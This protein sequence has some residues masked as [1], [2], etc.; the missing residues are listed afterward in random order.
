M[1][2]TEPGYSAVEASVADLLDAGMEAVHGEGL[3]ER[4]AEFAAPRGSSS[5]A[6]AVVRLAG[7]VSN[8]LEAEGLG[9]RSHALRRAVELLEEDP[10]RLVAR[11][12]IVHGFSD[13][14]G[15]A[16]DLIA[17]LMRFHAARVLIGEPPDPS[18]GEPLDVFVSHFRQR[19]ERDV[20]V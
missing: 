2:S 8:A 10:S 19:L 11:A 16:C 13:A 18:T 7:R 9:S 12:V 17:A 14:T 4:L 20:L 5:I 3:D 1:G 15:R 6:R